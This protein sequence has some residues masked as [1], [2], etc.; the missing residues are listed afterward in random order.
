MSAGN[1]RNISASDGASWRGRVLSR[2]RGRGR[3]HGGG[4]ARVSIV[5]HV[6]GR[7]RGRARGQGRGCIDEDRVVEYAIPDDMSHL[8]RRNQQNIQP[9][10]APQIEEKSESE[11]ESVSNE[12]GDERIITNSNLLPALEELLCLFKSYD[13]RVCIHHLFISDSDLCD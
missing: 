9:T 4:R 12:N 11:S 2:S 8:L 3:G 10:I 7:G 5:Q 13:R 1:T 6:S